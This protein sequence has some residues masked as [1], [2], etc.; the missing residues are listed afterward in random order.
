MESAVI[1]KQILS[2]ILKRN[3]RRSAWRICV[4]MLGFKELTL[5]QLLKHGVPKSIPPSPEMGPDR[6]KAISPA[7]C[8]KYPFTE[9]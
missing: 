4:W 8:P 9:I 2:T 7:V 5:N 1:L 6:S 3:V